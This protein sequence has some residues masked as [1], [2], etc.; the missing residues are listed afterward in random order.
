MKLKLVNPPNSLFGNLS[1]SLSLSLARACCLTFCFTFSDAE[2]K[3]LV[4]VQPVKEEEV[5]KQCAGKLYNCGCMESTG[6]I[7]SI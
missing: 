6:F 1:P 5:K 3:Y 4:A 7:T 2:P